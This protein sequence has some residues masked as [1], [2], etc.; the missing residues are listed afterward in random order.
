MDK[1]ALLLQ[2]ERGELS[3]AQVIDGLRDKE[4]GGDGTL[5]VAEMQVPTRQERLCMLAKGA[6][7]VAAPSLLVGLPGQEAAPWPWPEI[8]WQ[9]VWQDPFRPQHVDHGVAM[10]GGDTLYAVFYEGDVRVDGAEGNRAE[11]GGAFYDMRLGRSGRALYVAASAGSADLV[12]PAVSQLEIGTAPGDLRLAGVKARR[13]RAHCRSGAC[14]LE[15]IEG[16]VEVDLQGSDLDVTELQG[17]LKVRGRRAGVRGRLLAAPEIDIEVD[18]PIQ[19]DLGE[20]TTGR[21]HCKALAG[22]IEVSL[23][24]AAAVD[25]VAAAPVGGIAPCNPSW[26]ALRGRSPVEIDGAINGGGAAVHLEA[27]EGRVFVNII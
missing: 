15:K 10:D 6:S 16:D 26:S 1:S 27:T 11:F 9:W 22:D 8:E 7:S 23:A 21:V 12:L 5:A 25:L 14:R 13:L 19:L 3:V 4:P 18:G 20:I 24:A 2:L 17:Q